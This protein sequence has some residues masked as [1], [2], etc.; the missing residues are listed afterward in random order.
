MKDRKLL[1]DIFGRYLLI[2]LLGLGDLWIFYTL[3]KPATIHTLVSILRIFSG[4]VVLV[5]GRI[6]FESILIEIIPACV[7]GAAYYLLFILV[8]STPN[9][10]I[11]R[12]LGILLL[13]SLAFFILNILRLLILALINKSAY[14][15]TVHLLFWYALSTI[16]VVLI[17]VFSVKFFKIKDIPIYTDVRT[18]I[19]LAKG[20]KG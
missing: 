4:E 5:G 20:R 10:K 8:F 15:E 1:F 13:T 12:R 17:W 6:L 16:F 3:F 7:A 14:F 11:K 9:I 18:L 19:R 2:L